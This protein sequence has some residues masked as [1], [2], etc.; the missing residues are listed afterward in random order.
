MKPEHILYI[1]GGASRAGKTVI[2]SRILKEY[3]VPYFGL[4]Y[5]TGAVQLIPEAGVSHEQ[6]VMERTENLWPMVRALSENLLFAEPKY[7]MDGEAVFPKNLAEYKNEGRNIR[8]C[9]LGYADID[10]EVKFQQIRANPSPVND[11][12]RDRPDDV[13]KLNVSESINFSRFIR[14]ECKKWNMPYFDTSFEFEKNINLA[15][16]SLIDEK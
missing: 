3:G 4:D 11:W 10:P 13:L 8:A 5:L 12:S 16:K 6:N 9:F 15:I 14:D 2:A 1:V 7:L